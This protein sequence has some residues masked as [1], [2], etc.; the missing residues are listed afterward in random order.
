M[1]K[2]LCM[3]TFDNAVSINPYFKIPDENMEAAKGGLKEFCDLVKK[4]EPGCLFYNFT[5]KGNEMCCREAY[6]DADAV[7]AH[8]E[9]CGPALGEF[10][11]IAELLRIE[12]HGPAAAL[13]QLKETFAAFN[14]DYY[15]SECGIGN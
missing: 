11:K 2:E 4:N 8:L 9:N 1:E 15:V 10:L 7:K 3:S 5:F 12:V 13:E 6:K 14:P